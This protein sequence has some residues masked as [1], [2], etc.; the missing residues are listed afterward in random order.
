M[1]QMVRARNGIVKAV[2]LENTCLKIPIHVFFFVF[3][4]VVDPRIAV[5][6]TCISSG[7]GGREVKLS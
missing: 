7:E 6:E 5:S 1:Y 4:E 3:F 2:K